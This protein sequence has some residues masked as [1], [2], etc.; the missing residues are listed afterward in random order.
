MPDI[1]SSSADYASRFAGSVGRWFLDVQS[2]ALRNALDGEKCASVLDAGGGHGQNIATLQSLGAAIEVLGSG[3][4]IPPLIAA[5]VSLGQVSYRQGNLLKLPYADNTFDAAI[6]FRMLAHLD[7]WRGHIAELCR[8]SRQVVVVDFP[9]SRSVNTLAEKLF[10]LKQAVETNTRKYQLFDE[11][12]LNQVFVAQGF[13]PVFR[14]PQYFFPMALYRAIRV[15]PVAK[16][17]EWCA[18]KLGFGRAYGS[19]VIA[20]FRPD[21]ELPGRVD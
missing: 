13:H 21:S 4:E 7:D 3:P 10:F 16:A 17:M 20:A 9:S 19:P 18:H 6:S 2:T 11:A 14:A 8:V 12:E 5:Q 1:E 15:A